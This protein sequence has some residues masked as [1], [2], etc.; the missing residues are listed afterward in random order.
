MRQSSKS[1][2]HNQGEYNIVL[3]GKDSRKGR[4][5][6]FTITVKISESSVGTA[7]DYRSIKPFLF[8]HSAKNKRYISKII[9]TKMRQSIRNDIILSGETIVLTWLVQERF[10][11]KKIL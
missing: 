1:C 4:F 3:S 11:E 5:F 6:R 7:G 8:R 9:T 2:P 10:F